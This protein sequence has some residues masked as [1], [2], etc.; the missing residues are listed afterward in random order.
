[1]I[2]AKSPLWAEVD[3]NGRLQLP[4]P[5]IDQYGLQPGARV[6]IDQS[7]N[8][9]RLHRPVT[10]LNKV[11]IE[12]T[13]RCN[14][15]CITCMRNNWDVTFGNMS[16][17]TFEHVLDGLRTLP[18]PPT[19]LFG[20]IGEPTFHRDLPD[21]ITKA[22]ALGCRVEMITNGTLLTTE[23]SHQIIK[24]GLDML[25]VSLDGAQPHSYADVRLGA[26]LP[27]VLEN[28]EQFRRLRRPGHRPHPEMGIAF[29]AMQRNIGDL[30]ELLALGKRLG[31]MQFHVSNLLP[32]SAETSQDILYEQTLRSITYLPSP[33]L[34]QL[35]LP[36]MDIN[37]D[38]AVPF[39]EA[40]RSG[41]NVV[42]AGNNLGQSNDVCT[43]IES[44]SC[45]VGWDGSVSPCPPLLYTHTGYLR[46][47]ERVSH[48]HIIGNINE[49]D[50]LDLWLDA[51]YVA[52]RERVHQFAF[53]PC[54]A[55]GGCELSRENE[56]DCFDVPAPACGG[57]LWA[58]GVIQCP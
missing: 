12:P 41:Y 10:H 4:Q 1:M 55:C 38:T 14:L 5:L 56:T 8:S 49:R 7:S 29:V 25:W 51:D 19:V 6:R 52:Y 54:T 50:L 36:K 57:C 21:M 43:F 20:G 33:W 27:K 22:K 37:E 2:S 47:Y 18:A 58:Q 13:N 31:V 44:G 48:K 17:S 42:F 26:E 46:G 16:A 11:Y 15:D 9:F 32:H 3:E 30:P 39:L 40:L 24:A 23:K 28:L 45:V 34:R 53:A 35:H